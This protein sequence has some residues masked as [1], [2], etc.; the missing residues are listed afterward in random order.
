MGQFENVQIFH[1]FHFVPPEERTRNTNTVPIT[2]LG[3][4]ETSKR[5]TIATPAKEGPDLVVVA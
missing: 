3:I 4:P 5:S 1:T 2:F